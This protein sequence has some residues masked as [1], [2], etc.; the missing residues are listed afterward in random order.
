MFNIYDQANKVTYPNLKSGY[1][2]VPSDLEIRDFYSRFTQTFGADLDSINSWPAEARMAGLLWHEGA[3][4][5][6]RI[7]NGGHDGSGRPQRWVLYT[8]REKVPPDDAPGSVVDIARWL[9]DPAWPAPEEVP[10]PAVVPVSTYS[11]PKRKLSDDLFPPEIPQ[12]I[13]DVQLLW[14]EWWQ[15]PRR[16]TT[17]WLIFSNIGGK[18]SCHYDLVLK[19][20]ELPPIPRLNPPLRSVF[21]SA[22]D[23]A[24]KLGHKDAAKKKWN[25]VIVFLLVLIGILLL[26]S[27]VLF[28][29]VFFLLPSEKM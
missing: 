22:G 9:G 3:L 2:Q 12:S 4:Y 28:S 16:E 19:E 10:L 7:H 20:E 15:S 8:W 27:A 17:G 1:W 25:N 6:M 5:L 13:E 11:V 29:V 24:A 26:T 18:F 21:V 14:T 23:S